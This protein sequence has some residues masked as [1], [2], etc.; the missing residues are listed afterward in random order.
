MYPIIPLFP[1]E[2]SCCVSRDW[3]LDTQHLLILA[4]SKKMVRA[5]L[6]SLRVHGAGLGLSP[7]GQA[8]RMQPM[9]VRPCEPSPS[10]WGEGF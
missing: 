2:T 9:R 4:N 6:P 5:S 10:E 8:S 7:E 3:P 1:A